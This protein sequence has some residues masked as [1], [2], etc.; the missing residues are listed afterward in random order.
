MANRTEILNKLFE[1][2]SKSI[3]LDS[4]IDLSNKD[5]VVIIEAVSK[6][7]Q[8]LIYSLEKAENEQN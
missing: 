5:S 7:F 8:A 3:I 6:L 4:I 2:K 1:E